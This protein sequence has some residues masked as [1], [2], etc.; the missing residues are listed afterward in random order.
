MRWP[1]TPT[2]WARVE[3]SDAGARGPRVRRGPRPAMPA[4]GRASSVARPGWRGGP[5]DPGGLRVRA[6]LDG[7]TIVLRNC[8]FDR[9][10]RDHRDLVCGM[11]RSIMDGLVTG[12]RSS[13]LQAAFDPQA[14]RCCMTFQTAAAPARIDAEQAALQVAHRGFLVR[15]GVVPAAHVERAVGDEEA[16]LVGGRPAHVPGLTAPARAGLVDRPF[17]RDDDVAEVRSGAGRQGEDGPRRFRPV[18]G[19]GMRPEDVRWQQ[20]ERQHVGRA[21]HA[22]VRGVQS[23]KLGV[24]GEDQSDGRRA[25]RTGRIEGGRHGPRQP[26]DPE[27]HL[28]AVPDGHI[29]PPRRPVD[30]P[31]H[32]AAGPPPPPPAARLAS[33]STTSLCG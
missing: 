20:R 17:H 25:G 7:A 9:V 11:N 8:P 2:A 32:E 3:R 24:V 28:D 6:I 21:A 33:R 10:A 30:G 27:R 15:S 19:A 12:L 23:G 14:G 5:G 13:G 31:G 4:A 22:H 1:S 26:G 18:R 29:E 16:Q